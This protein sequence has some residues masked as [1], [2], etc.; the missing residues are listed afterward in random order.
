MGHIPEIGTG[1]RCR[2]ISSTRSTSSTY[3][4]F[5]SPCCHVQFRTAFLLVTYDTPEEINTAPSVASS[6]ASGDSE[7]SHSE[8]LHASIVKRVESIAVISLMISNDLHKGII[9]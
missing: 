7:A 9:S 5:P 2:R 3:P 8:K 1:Y 4:R 6:L